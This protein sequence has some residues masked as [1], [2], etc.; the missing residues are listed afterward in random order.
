MYMYSVFTGTHTSDPHIKL[1]IAL[2]LETFRL[3]SNGAVFNIYYASQILV[4]IGGFELRT[5]FKQFKYR[6]N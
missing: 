3:N 6:T 4:I 1:I 5:S 2:H